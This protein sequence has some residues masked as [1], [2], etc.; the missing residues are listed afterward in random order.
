MARCYG[1]P[2]VVDLFGTV[3]GKESSTRPESL[4]L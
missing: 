3:A 1:K 2:N 4:Y